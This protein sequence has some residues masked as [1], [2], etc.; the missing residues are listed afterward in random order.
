MGYLQWEVAVEGKQR[1]WV[2][3]EEGRTLDP[4]PYGRCGRPAAADDTHFHQG[5]VAGV[6]VPAVRSLP[7][8]SDHG[9]GGD[10]GCRGGSP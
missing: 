6:V 1:S 9:G 2:V 3:D 4:G 5:S 10:G 7:H 8:L